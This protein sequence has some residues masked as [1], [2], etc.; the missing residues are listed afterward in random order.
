MPFHTFVVSGGFVAAAL[1]LYLAVYAYRHR[2]TEAALPFSLL[3]SANT[4]YA[5]GY[6]TE[7]LMPTLGATVLLLKV[8]Y[9]GAMLAPVFF[10][11]FAET[12]ID[13][14]RS[15]IRRFPLLVAAVP[16]LTIVLM[17]TN[18]AHGLIFKS[19]SLTPGVP[20]SVI[21]T[22]RGI[23]YGPTTGYAYLLLLIGT[24][25]IL[26]RL[27]RVAGE[28]RGQTLVIA[29][30]VLV[31]WA[32]HIILVLKKGP[33][34]IDP[35][36]F[37]LAISG[38]LLTFAIFKLRLF[39]LVP[40]ARD[41]VV[42][43]MRDAVVVLDERG[44]VV[45]SNVAAKTIF[46]GIAR[47][48]SQA[49]AEEFFKS[50][51]FTLPGDEE[52]VET[53]VTVG[54]KVRKFRVD[55]EGVRN[56]RGARI[57]TAVIFA[58]TT[59]TQDLLWRLAELAT[60]D[61]LTGSYNRRHFYTIAEREMDL[62]RR[63]DRPV[64]L[65]MFDLDLFKL[66]NDERGHGAGDAALKSVCDVCRA[67]LRSSDILCRFGGEEFVILFPE[68]TPAEAIEIAERLRIAISET[69]VQSGSE[70]FRV[71]AS[72]GVSGSV[73][74]PVGS[75]EYYLKEADVAMYRAKN[76]GR[77]RVEPRP[78]LNLFENPSQN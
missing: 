26:T 59:E 21:K 6:A 78:Q 36:P 44:R 28:F 1:S 23:L 76:A 18:E 75:L 10:L 20:L 2:S 63:N 58:D 53:A 61:E 3:M 29:A 55:A 22:R 14:P 13:S 51:D 45:D 38:S 68:A 73:G 48:S 34:N 46:P 50:F 27:R 15:L 70:A 19:I 32:G 8:E 37:L 65:A 69:V 30:A 12:F 74:A 57:G 43:A 24:V 41:Y 67:T 16:L 49:S 66:V 9:I 60:T 42:D 5:L 25:R 64:S 77:N 52:S 39:D 35:T 31:P 4:V 72:F 54:G 47:L 62:A 40:I 17:W 33:F 71:T 56:A 7:L 11:Y